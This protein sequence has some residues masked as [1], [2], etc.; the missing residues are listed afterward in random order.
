MRFPL[1]MIF[2]LGDLLMLWTCYEVEYNYPLV[3]SFIVHNSASFR[4]RVVVSVL[5]DSG[6]LTFLSEPPSADENRSPV[7]ETL[8]ILLVSAG[9]FPYRVM[10]MCEECLE[11][12]WQF[13]R[14]QPTMLS[15]S[16]T[17]TQFERNL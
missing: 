12:H 10:I 15:L 13:T 14:L 9:A 6:R 8:T 16:V 7:I 2:Q 17:L 5:Y 3:T 11:D 4:L 1:N